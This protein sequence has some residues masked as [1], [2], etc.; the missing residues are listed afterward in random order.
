M[1]KPKIKLHCVLFYSCVI[2]A[3]NHI[4][5]LFKQFVYMCR[6]E[7]KMLSLH[8]FKIYI[9]QIQKIEYKITKKNNKIICHLNKCKHLK[10]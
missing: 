4:L 6:D 9:D 1:Y 10:Q 2:W 3:Q 8:K 5:L 7:T